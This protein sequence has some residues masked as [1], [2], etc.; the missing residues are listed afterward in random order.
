M[1]QTQRIEVSETVSLKQCVGLKHAIDN[2]TDYVE[3]KKS[4]VHFCNDCSEGNILTLTKIKQKKFPTCLDKNTKF[5]PYCELQ[6]KFSDEKYYC[7][8]TNCEAGF[9][10]VKIGS[11]DDM[12]GCVQESMI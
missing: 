6:T 9:F 7:V 1:H 2:C 10:Q 11:E 8:N 3:I 12:I 5:L 4:R